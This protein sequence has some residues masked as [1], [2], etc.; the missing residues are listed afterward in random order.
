[1]LNGGDV[2]EIE[3][4]LLNGILFLHVTSILFYNSRHMMQAVARGIFETIVDQSPFAIEDLMKEVKTNG[5][6]DDLSEEDE[7]KDDEEGVMAKGKENVTK[8]NSDLERP[9]YPKNQGS[10]TLFQ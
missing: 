10:K 9:G 4:F 7:L 8:I 3:K 2:F 1:M 5:G 6:G